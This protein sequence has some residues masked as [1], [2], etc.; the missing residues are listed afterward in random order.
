MRVQ[1]YKVDFNLFNLYIE[2][3]ALFLATIIINERVLLTLKVQRY[4][5]FIFLYRKVSFILAT[6]NET[7]LLAIRTL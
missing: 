1:R 3:R 4:K 7:V 5:A 6:I 2:R